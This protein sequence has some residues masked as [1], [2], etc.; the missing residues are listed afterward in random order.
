MLKHSRTIVYLLFVLFAV[1]NISYAQEKPPEV[2]TLQEFIKQ[3]CQ[4]DTVFQQILIDELS[5][6]YEKRLQLPAADLVMSLEGQYDFL[7]KPNYDEPESNVSLSKLFPYT[8]TEV[9]AEYSSSLGVTTRRVTSDFIVKISQPIAQTRL[10][11]VILTTLTTVVGIIPTAYG[12][13]GYDA[14]LAQM[15]MALAWGLLFGTLITLILI[16]SIYAVT[17]DIK[18]RIKHV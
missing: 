17:Q 9:E 6:K 14:M 13:A 15:M 18:Y 12:W 3:V 2:L 1:V 11:A 8:G 10:R 5:L 4:R 7:Y 16:P